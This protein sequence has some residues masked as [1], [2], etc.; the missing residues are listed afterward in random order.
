MRERKPKRSSARPVVNLP[1]VYRL[2]AERRHQPRACIGF[3][4][5]RPR[6]PSRKTRGFPA[7]AVSYLDESQT[8]DAWG[9]WDV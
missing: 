2:A 3:V 4:P 6:R 1:A 7:D 5:T 8:W 9:M